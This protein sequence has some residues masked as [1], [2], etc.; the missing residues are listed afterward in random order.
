MYSYRPRYCSEWDEYFV[1][2]RY[3]T[4]LRPNGDHQSLS[5]PV[6]LGQSIIITDST[7][8]N[9][10]VKG[11]SQG[12]YYNT[13]FVRSLAYFTAWKCAHCHVLNEHNEQFHYVK[14]TNVLI[15]LK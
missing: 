2:V 3:C 9:P 11:K 15:R 1:S 6:T 13:R 4:Y 12:L 5:Q 14:S 8:H 7:L 10:A